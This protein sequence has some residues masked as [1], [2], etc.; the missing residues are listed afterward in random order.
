MSAVDLDRVR[1]LEARSRTLH[2]QLALRRDLLAAVDDHVQEWLER[3]PG[4]PG[5]GPDGQPAVDALQDA[6]ITEQ[7]RPLGEVLEIVGRGVDHVGVNESS[8][9]FFG[10]IP[11]SGLYFGALA[12]YHAAVVNRYAG[13]YYAA[14]GA[15]RL[16]RA[17]I[18]WLAGVLGY[19]TDCGGDITSGGSI[20]NL[21][22]LVTARDACDL[23]SDGFAES[24]IY[25]S[26]QTHHAVDK[27]IRI[28]GLGDAQRRL[29][30]LDDRHR[31]R[32]DALARLVDEDRRSGLRPFL[33]VA[34]AGATDTGAVDPLDAI[35]DVCEQRSLWFHVDAA[36]GGAFALTADGARRLRGIA[37]SDSVV[38]DPHK[39]FFL[40]FGTGVVLVKDRAHMAQAFAGTASYLEDA[41][42][43][44]PDVVTS[45]AELSPELTRP[46][47]ALRWWLSLQ[48]AGVDAFRAALEEKLL[49]AR[50]AHD[51]IGALDGFEVGPR[52]DLS[53]F[54]FRHV[55]NGDPDATNRALI[56]AI[57]AD[58]RI[59]VSATV[60]DNRY[61]PRFAVLNCRTHLAEVDRAVD[62]IAELAGR[63]T[64]SVQDR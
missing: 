55:A 15:V 44:E 17:C 6:P 25:L 2:P 30:P 60:L 13:V 1:E 52:P 57:H 59:Y 46:F 9:S 4:L 19:P 36:Y 34:S 27:A 43:S 63:V 38:V 7:P 12:D 23:R 28:A 50:H 35:A 8:G 45:P 53:V 26:S 31:M 54:T 42:A 22:A 33:V 3:L 40:P 5:Y 18:E 58:G 37:R 32:A 62:V 10:Y 41:M 56:D 49:L 51:R 39:G 64:A 47:R 16:G 20:A 11:G 24:V 48:L 14:P 21:S 61:T 29:V